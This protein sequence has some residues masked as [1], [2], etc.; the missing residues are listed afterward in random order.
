MFRKVKKITKYNIGDVVSAVEKDDEG[1]YRIVSKD[2]S[3]GQTIKLCGVVSSRRNKTTKNNTQMAFVSLEDMFASIEIIVFP[4]VLDRYSYLL[5]EDE[6]VV[7]EGRVSFREDEDPKILCE[8]VTS[9]DNVV[10]QK[11]FIKIKTYSEEQINLIKKIAKESKGNVPICIYVEDT[12][13]KLMASNKY[14][15]SANEALIKK[16]NDS[17]GAENVKLC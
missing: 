9:I 11:L 4:K 10:S 12:K 15:V 2:I 5:A 6:T 3:D 7:I 16:F 13:K 17:F 14:W 8:T 1:A